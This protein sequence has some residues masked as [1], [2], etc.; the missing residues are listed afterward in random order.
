MIESVATSVIKKPTGEVFQFVATL[1]NFPYWVSGSH[2]VKLSEGLFSEGTLFQQDN[3]VVRVSHFQVNQGFE[4]ESI[5]I[6]FPARFVLKHTHGMLHFEKVGPGT[7]FTFKH[8]FEL[9]AFAKPFEHM[10]AKKAQIEIQAA[11]EKLKKLL[12]SS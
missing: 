1:E 3:V 9:T 5:T 4:T 12:E 8:Q 10:I 11:L 7:Q 6:H 2:F